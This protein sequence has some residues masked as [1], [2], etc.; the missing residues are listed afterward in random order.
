[1]SSISRR[2]RSGGSRRSPRLLRAVKPVELW[3]LRALFPVRRDSEFGVLRDIEKRTKIWGDLWRDA[4]G[5][6]PDPRDLSLWAI[7][8]HCRI[9]WL[10]LSERKEEWLPKATTVPG[11][12]RHSWVQRTCRRHLSGAR[13]ASQQSA[14]LLRDAGGYVRG[15]RL[16]RGFWWR[17]RTN[18][19][20]LDRPVIAFGNRP[21]A[22]EFTFELPA[23]PC[24]SGG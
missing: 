16:S 19:L 9:C 11:G 23:N 4:G 7:N 3:V 8:R 17:R 21:I 22:T 6:P 13:A 18:A 15:R 24:F 12:A 10:A 1:M 20:A 5:Q 2:K 14:V